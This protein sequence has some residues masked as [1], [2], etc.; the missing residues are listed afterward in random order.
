[1]QWFIW[2]DLAVGPS[3]TF[4]EGLPDRQFPRP[5]S[6]VAIKWNCLL[7]RNVLHMQ[8]EM[9]DLLIRYCLTLH[10]QQVV[11]EGCQRRT[12]VA[13][14]LSWSGAGDPSLL[15]GPELLTTATASVCWCDLDRG[16]SPFSSFMSG[17][18]L[19]ESWEKEEK[20]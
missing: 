20:L 5:G 2:R 15:G 16:R 14:L 17:S 19:R 11:S 13:A 18:E 10:L 6:P 8:K 12:W 4:S 9:V 1:M 3:L 7:Q